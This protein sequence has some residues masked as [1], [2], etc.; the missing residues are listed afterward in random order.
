LVV[1][2]LVVAEEVV[3]MRLQLA[4]VR[5]MT[6]AA[7]MITAPRAVCGAAP[8]TLL[9]IGYLFFTSAV[10]RSVPRLCCESVTLCVCV[11]KQAGAMTSQ[12]PGI[13]NSRLSRV[14]DWFLQVFEQ[15]KKNW[16]K[17]VYCSSH[18]FLNTK[19]LKVV[20]KNF[21]SKL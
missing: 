14:R 19:T 20:F 5:W 16:K 4:E 15:T 3:A 2:S 18:I 1:V 13:S 8:A 6:R 12:I 10:T 17:K 11:V 9:S 21:H 7:R